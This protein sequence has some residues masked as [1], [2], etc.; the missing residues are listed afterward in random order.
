M[1][2]IKT[3]AVVI[4]TLVLGFGSLL[5]CSNEETATTATPKKQSKLISELAAYNQTAQST[6]FS[7]R[8]CSGFWGCLGYVSQVAGADII[9][10]ATGVVGVSQSA[11]ALGVAT[12]GT[13]A[14]VVMAGAGVVC[15]GGASYAAAR[16]YDPHYVKDN[17]EYGTQAIEVPE[18]FQGLSNVGINHN[19]VLHNNFFNGE[20]LDSYYNANFDIKQIEL[21]KSDYM[22]EV[23]KEVTAASVDYAKNNFD[24]KGFTQRMVDQKYFTE[25]M[26]SVMGLFLEKYVTCKEDLE[27]EETINYYIQAVSKSGLTTVEKQALIASF[28]VASESPFYFYKDVE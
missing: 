26:K 27:L 28:M 13:G 16:T 25:D 17:L 10:A 2:K 14:V 4:L 7:K 15:G 3:A 11:A 1:K 9:G 23:N 18:E 8:K 6:A 20:S 19:T 5:S 12:G 21:L 22:K 24:Y